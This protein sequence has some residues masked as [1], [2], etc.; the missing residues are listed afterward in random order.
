M[1]IV[2]HNGTLIAHSLNDLAMQRINLGN[3]PA[4]VKSMEGTNSTQ[5]FRQGS[6]YYLES[7]TR[8]PE[9]LWVVSVG[10]NMNEVMAP[11]HKLRNLLIATMLIAI[12]LA[13]A[14][15]LW[16]IRRLML[17]LTALGQ[18]TGQIADGNYDFSFRPSGLLEID[19]LANQ[20]AS[21]ASAIKVREGSIVANEQRFR[22]L[23]NSIDGIVWEM[24]YPSFN[25]LF[26]SRQAEAIVGYSIQ[27]W[28]EVPDFWEKTVYGED[29]AQAKSYCQL[30]SEKQEDHDF[31]YR[32]VTADGRLVWIR[33][34]VT[35]VVEDN[36]P[37]RLLGVMIDVTEQKELVDELSRSEQNYREIF[38]STSDAIFI[39]DA[40]TS[41]IL[42]VNQAMMNMFNC[43]YETALASSLETFS[44]GESPYSLQEASMKL[45]IAK[46][47]GSCTFEW[48]SR[49]ATGEVFWSEVTLRSASIGNQQRILAAVRDIS[50]RKEAVENLRTVNER[51]LLL[52]NRMP[53]GCIF[54]TP[55]FLIDMWNPAAEAIF[56][57]SE[58]EMIGKGP[59]GTIVS[60][61]TQPEVEK[62][63]NKLR[64]GDLA[65]HSLNKNITKTGKTITCEWYNTPVSDLSGNI[66]GTISMAQD[67]SERKATED[68]LA[69]YRFD[70]EQ[71]ISERTEQL[72]KAQEELVRKERLAVL[73]QLTTTVSHEIRNPLGTIANS[74]Y[75]LRHALQGEEHEALHK[76]LLLAER[77]VDRCDGI[78]SDLLD[79]S[80][81]RKSQK[82]RFAFDTWFAEVLEELAIPAEVQCHLDF[83]SEA[84]VSADSERLRRV[85][86]N[87]ITNALQALD[88][89]QNSDKTLEIQTRIVDDRCE[90]RVRDNGPGMSEEILSRIFEPMFSTKNFG[91]GLGVPIIKNILESHGGEVA[92][93]SE[94]GKGT[95]VFMY[96]PLSSE[97]SDK[98]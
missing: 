82:E 9:S 3:H 12:L 76:P 55:D 17:P 4:V 20:I 25:F 84:A 35:V 53:L 83:A 22:D 88:E 59:Y 19:T 28:Y 70:L 79:F 33:D 1:S 98:G 50:A 30:M 80:R 92:Y 41:Q 95:T 77:N 87:V 45:Q 58:E 8:V 69:K 16:N 44:L 29:L 94:V 91:V 34:L 78:I 71:L 14:I 96:L 64:K 23:V 56:G 67:V 86:V 27:D 73:G 32:M 61:E 62:V 74:L 47:E 37:V 7:A 89:K 24:E 11:I 2:D 49:K 43:S 72:N 36:R 15:A 18:R 13:C 93:I 65:A 81:Q 26:V 63:L 75:L 51:L 46:D 85:V 38:N 54:W 10:L 39:H 90:I 66:I 40:D 60:E 21:M 6:S 42:D 52:I 48:Y 57:F 68:E 97:G 31:T 5:E